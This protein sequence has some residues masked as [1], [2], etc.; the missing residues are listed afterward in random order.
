MKVG[1]TMRHASARGYREDRDAIARGWPVF[2]RQYLPDIQWMLMPSLPVGDMLEYV[3]SWELDGFLLTGGD[4]PGTDS[5][6]DQAEEALLEY[7]VSSGKPVLG[8]CRG[9]QVIQRHL[10]GVLTACAASGYLPSAHTV[11]IPPEM[12]CLFSGKTE[13]RV[14]SYHRMGIRVKDLAPPLKPVA[15]T[16]GWV[17]CAVSDKPA[18]M[19][20]LWHPERAS[21]EPLLAGHLMER[22][23]QRKIDLPKT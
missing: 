1:L 10:G 20:M 3:K 16:D 22:F 21:G 4:D 17:E 12:R 5:L 6:R 7:A 23:F 8:V 15:M 2:L 13:M 9:F 14:N 19:G 11:H 18:L